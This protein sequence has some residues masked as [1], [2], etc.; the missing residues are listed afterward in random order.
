MARWNLSSWLSHSVTQQPYVP[1]TPAAVRGQVYVQELPAR[2]N[3]DVD[4]QLR[5]GS[6]IAYRASRV[7]HEF[8]RSSDVRALRAQ[9]AN[10]IWVPLYTGFVGRRRILNHA[11]KLHEVD[12]E[13]SRDTYARTHSHTPVSP[14]SHTPS[15]GRRA[16]TPA[17]LAIEA[18]RSYLCRRNGSRALL[19]V[20][21]E[22]QGPIRLCHGLDVRGH[23]NLRPGLRARRARHRD[24]ERALHKLLLLPR[25]RSG[26]PTLDQRREVHGTGASASPRRRVFVEVATPLFLG[27][28]KR[29]CKLSRRPKPV[30]LA[31]PQRPPP[32][33][34]ARG[35][36]RFG[37]LVP[38]MVAP[39]SSRRTNG[40]ALC[41][42]ARSPHRCEGGQRPSRAAEAARQAGW[43]RQEGVGHASR[44]P[45]GAS[46]VGA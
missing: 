29:T 16:S 28:T 39:R 45:L 19:P 37:S 32:H 25:A 17:A 35:V 43:S 44:V 26:H 24:G 15:G 42:R 13:K 33:L 38:S 22:R 11:S 23:Q 34:A 18:S 21:L 41:T 30:G 46:R 31:P 14:T 8:V 4:T 1:A 7:L 40:C 10:A 12:A 6:G 3:A 9:D 27:A 20:R 36:H 5:F 2:F